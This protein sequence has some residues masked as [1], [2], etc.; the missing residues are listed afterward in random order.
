MNKEYQIRIDR[1]LQYIEAN[2][3]DSISLTEV[4]KV[5]YFSPYHF[6]RIFSAIMGE[7]VNDYIGR[8]KLERAANMLIFNT[9]LS[10]TQVALD[11]GF[12][13]S[14]N[15]SKAVKL[16]FGFSPSEIRNPDKVKDSKIGKIYRKYGKVFCP[17][18]LYPSRITNE[19]MNNANVKDIN[20]K[21]EVKDFVSQR[22]CM[23]SSARG[24]QPESIFATWDKLIEWAANNG[25]KHDEQ[26]RFAFAYDNPT[27]TPVDKCR[28]DAAIVIADSLDVNSPF[29]TTE[30]PEGK[31]A[32][33]YFKGAPEEAI[34]AQL[35]LYSDWL[36]NSGFEPD[37]FPMLEHYLNDARVDGY[38]EM[39]IRVK[40]KVMSFKQ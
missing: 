19:V 6:H 40:V 38:V 31:Y 3:T 34:Q 25:I 32:V 35:S 1:V 28:Y 29:T 27:V 20:M 17:A 36:P 9:E 23:L 5:S 12:S 26:Q 7:T 13:S 33:V 15:F 4:A 18:D 2:L 16:Y 8:R 22:V 39:E 24:Y 14:A 37:N 10:I 11:C 30:I 21:V